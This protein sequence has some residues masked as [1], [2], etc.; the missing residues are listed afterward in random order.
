MER[1][2]FEFLRAWANPAGWG[3]GTP[4]ARDSVVGR[5]EETASPEEQQR[6]L[7]A[8]RI[9]CPVL[10]SMYRRGWLNPTPAGVITWQ[11]LFACLRAI[12]FCRASA[13]G[14]AVNIAAYRGDDTAQ[15]TRDR[16]GVRR[17]LNIFS[18]SPGETSASAAM[19]LQHGFSTIIR[20]SRFDAGADAA[21]VRESRKARFA[22]VFGGEEVMTLDPATGERRCY[23]AGLARVLGH[24][25][26]HG[27][28]AGEWSSD[29]IAQTHPKA[30]AAGFGSELSEWQ[31]VFA[32]SFFWVA[33]GE[34]DPDGRRY[35]SEAALESMFLDSQVPTYWAGG[36]SFGFQEGFETTAAL[37][38][39]T[40]LVLPRQ[41]ETEL[42]QSRTISRLHM[43]MKTGGFLSKR[44]LDLDPDPVPAAEPATAVDLALRAASYIVLGLGF[45]Q[46]WAAILLQPDEGQQRAA[47][48]AAAGGGGG[49]GD[50]GGVGIGVGM[51][52]AIAAIP[53]V[54][55][56]ASLFAHAKRCAH[57]QFG[58][59]AAL[60]S[61]TSSA[62]GLLQ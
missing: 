6:R 20:D 18:M 2:V 13:H 50:G 30:A 21:A 42:L 53:T 62:E 11:E 57:S 60:A 43:G 12:G 16:G 27:D 51:G 24:A 7:N 37:G 56:A 49:D 40:G 19:Q 61:Q 26:L 29:N 8:H 39:D 5:P 1:L 48:E 45:F 58:P 34:T 55:L 15:T 4:L 38:S 52:V 3:V 14:Q 31:P 54:C 59:T 9:A 47:D 46:G 41:V 28:K 32:W 35:M 22:E 23:L 44:G 25:K 10:A 36:R 33:F 17:F